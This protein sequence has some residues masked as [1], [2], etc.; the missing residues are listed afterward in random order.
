MSNRTTATK[1]GTASTKKA[2]NR[3]PASKAWDTRR[4]KAA[5]ERKRRKRIAAKAVA[6]R[7]RNAAR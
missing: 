4:A 3:S 2:D 1:R 7:K 6:T 5:A